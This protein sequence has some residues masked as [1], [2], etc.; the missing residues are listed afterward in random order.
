MDGTIAEL[1]AVL[2]RMNREDIINVIGELGMRPKRGRAT[3]KL[4]ILT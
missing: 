2:K 4:Y 3:K 1:T